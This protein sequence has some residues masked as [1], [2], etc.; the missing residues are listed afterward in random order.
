MIKYTLAALVAVFFISSCQGA[1]KLET[2]E[3]PKRKM[4]VVVS[5]CHTLD[6]INNLAEADQVAAIEGAKLFNEYESA[7]IC[8]SYPRPLISVLTNFQRSYLDWQGRQTEIW[9]IMGTT[10]WTLVTTAS[11]GPLPEPKKKA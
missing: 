1:D 5:A 9:Q 4:G 8:G 11:T 10:L 6:A 3:A 7:G 2:V